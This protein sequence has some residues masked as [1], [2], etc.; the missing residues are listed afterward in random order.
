M[1]S[2]LSLTESNLVFLTIEKQHQKIGTET[3]KIMTDDEYLLW[4]GGKNG[5]NECI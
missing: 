4:P 1:E 3:G 2:R 5:Y